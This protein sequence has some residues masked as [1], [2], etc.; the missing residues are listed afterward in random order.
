MGIV[1]P[2]ILGM[3]LNWKNDKENSVITAFVA[4]HFLEWGIFQFMVLPAIYMKM[5]LSRFIIVYMAILIAFSILSIVLNAKA[6][7]GRIRPSNWKI[8]ISW[9]MCIAILLMAFQIN[10]IVGHQH[11]DEDDAFY[12]ATSETAVTTDAIMQYDAYTG[13]AYR[14]LPSRYVLSPFPIYISVL[15]KMVDVRPVTMAHMIYPVILMI[16]A[17]MIYMLIGREAFESAQSRGYF[18]IF[19]LLAIQFSGYTVYTQS[20]FFFFRLWQGKAVLATILIPAIFW[21]VR[22]MWDRSNWQDWV[23]MSAIMIATCMVSSMGIMLG[24]I[25]TS[26]LGIVWL[27]DKKSVKHAIGLWATCLPNIICAVIYILIR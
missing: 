1:L 9:T 16:I 20:S 26:I 17:Y 27:I 25:A 2:E 14:T 22:R 11:T 23:L 10:Y 8:N 12:V 6:I 4:G 13:K 24:A 5:S 21:Q 3:L 7:I 19:V 18:M 15:S